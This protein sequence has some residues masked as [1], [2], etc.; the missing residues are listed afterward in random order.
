MLKEIVTWI[1]YNDFKIIF[2]RTENFYWK[3]L[4]TRDCFWLGMLG[5]GA[6]VWKLVLMHLNDFVEWLGYI[7][8]T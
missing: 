4:S 3:C 8:P 7:E 6:D 1:Y 5:G 2:K